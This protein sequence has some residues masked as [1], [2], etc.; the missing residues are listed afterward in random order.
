M[1]FKLLDFQDIYTA[2]MA[3][4]KVPLTDT[5]TLERIKRDIN[6][7]YIHEVVPYRRWW[8]LR[9]NTRVVHKA[10]NRVSASVNPDS[11]AVTLSSAPDVGLG[12]FAGKVFSTDGFNEV[13]E[14]ASH[15]AGST[16]LTLTSAYQ[17]Q[18]AVEK[19]SIIW[20]Q[21]INLPT[22]CRETFEVWHDRMAKPL[23]GV[24]I[25]EYRRISSTGVKS[26]A[27]PVY[28]STTD[29]VA[30]S[31]PESE[32][33]R[34]RVMFLHP[35][36]SPNS[37]NVTINIDYIKE[38]ADLDDDSDEP[39]IPREDR[40]VLVYGALAKAWSRERNEEA[41]G[42]SYT[43]FQNK[44]AKMA[45]D[46]EDSM[47]TPMFSPSSRYLAAKRSSGLRRYRGDLYSTGSF[48]QASGASLPTY[49]KDVTIEGAILTDNMTVNSGITIDGRD[50][51]ADGAGLD[52]HIA[53]SSGV[54]GVTGDVLGTSD[55]QTIINKDIDSDNNTITNIVNADIKA[56]AAIA[57][58]KIAMGAANYVLINNASGVFSEEQY[59]SKARGGAAADMSSVT[60]PS[61]GTLVTEDGTHTLTNKGIDS[62]TNTI[63]NIVNADIKA[64]AGIN[65]NKLEALTADRAAEIDSSGF[66]KSSAITADELAYL[67]DVVK[68]T[69]VTLTDNTTDGVAIALDDANTSVI[70]EYSASRGAT[71]LEVGHIYMTHDGSNVDV[72]PVGADLG[73]TGLT[74][75][76]DL[77]SGNVR[78]LYTTTSTGTD[79]TFK[80]KL[81]KWAA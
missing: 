69:T 26:E 8:W 25:Q 65:V 2:V 9:G 64:A 15:T 50:I 61:S 47:D 52:A 7:T 4:L 21:F 53:A 18:A 23:Q 31:S 66:L 42:R 1:A 59:L 54:H 24:G 71:N 22:D 37:E 70:I 3:E 13:Y 30:P 81:H 34:Y 16:S 12:S 51:S 78:L 35:A 20:E 72:S 36:I 45:G 32:T 41:A 44:L 77:D 5:T 57:R 56:T 67:D 14:I 33:D 6:M 58:T 63:T 27:Y 11:T 60:F 39:V 49:L 73:T 62:D 75:S 28:Y 48:G 76:G 10:P 80:Y 68:L 17:G 43:Q 46:V 19:S 29:H 55:A 79:V 74:F 40:I 38:T